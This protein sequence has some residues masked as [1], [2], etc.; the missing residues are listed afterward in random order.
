MFVVTNG[1]VVERVGDDFVAT[2]S[3]GQVVLLSGRAGSAMACFLD[4]PTQLSDTDAQLLVSAGVLESVTPHTVSRRQLVAGGA[5]A[6][7]A[8]I[9]ALALPSA[10]HAASVIT[11]DSAD[12]WG[13][14]TAAVDF[15]F[16]QITSDYLEITV[17]VAPEVY[18]QYRENGGFSTNSGWPD[19]VLADG[20]WVVQSPSGDTPLGV[21]RDDDGIVQYFF[22]SEVRAVVEP[23]GQWP[24]GLFDSIS[25]DWSA[26]RNTTVFITNGSVVIPVTLFPIRRD[27]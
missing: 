22:Y 21:S 18:D 8:G 9:V 25:D 7:G 23:G 3:S 13:D 27:G 10:A 12:V 17:Y 20:D 5:G 14:Y 6:V 2:D 11:L 26:G 19:G 24:A 16:S 15:E 1:V 4:A